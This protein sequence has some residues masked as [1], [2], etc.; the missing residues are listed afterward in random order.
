MKY[1]KKNLLCTIFLILFSMTTAYAEEDKRK[2]I[3]KTTKTNEEPSHKFIG[4]KV[5]TIAPSDQLNWVTG[6]EKACNTACSNAGFI[7]AIARG[8]G[9]NEYICRVKPQNRGY[10]VGWNFKGISS[11][12][13]AYP[14]DGYQSQNYDCFCYKKLQ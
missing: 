7:G 3:N 10:I 6:N 13:C 1:N 2:T 14:G 4:E 12:G 5:V 8:D 9:Y 11:G